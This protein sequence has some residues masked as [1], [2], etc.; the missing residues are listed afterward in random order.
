VSASLRRA[1]MRT[2]RIEPEE[3]AP[4]SRRRSEIK[5]SSEDILT[6]QE[7]QEED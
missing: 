6:V 3:S 7:V 1:T 5:R 4:F 2:D